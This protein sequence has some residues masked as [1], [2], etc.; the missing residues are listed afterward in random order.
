MQL[1][2]VFSKIPRY[3]LSDIMI[4]SVAGK[5][6]DNEFNLKIKISSKGKMHGE[7]D[8]KIYREGK[9]WGVK[10]GMEE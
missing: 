4:C 2:P 8:F 7:N 6:S 1:S 5:V 10:V 3:L 9:I